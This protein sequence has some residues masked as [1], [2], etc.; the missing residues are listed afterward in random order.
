MPPTRTSPNH[1]S[2]PQETTFDNSKFDLRVKFLIDGLIHVIVSVSSY[3]CKPSQ[4]SSSHLSGPL[5]RAGVREEM[6]S[7]GALGDG[8]A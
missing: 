2:T 3:E 4:I 8:L 6:R 7:C 5:Y 1:H